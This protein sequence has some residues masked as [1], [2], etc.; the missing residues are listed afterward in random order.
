MMRIRPVSQEVVDTQ[1]GAATHPT[2]TA[3]MNATTMIVA[4]ITAVVEVPTTPASTGL[5]Q[6]SVAWP[7]MGTWLSQAVKRNMTSSRKD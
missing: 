3:T 4:T 6:C 2:Q 7:I 5:K 1:T